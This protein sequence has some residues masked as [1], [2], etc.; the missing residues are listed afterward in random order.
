M[1]LDKLHSLLDDQYNWPDHYTFKFVG[2]DEHRDQLTEVIG[3]APTNER[4]SSSGKYISYSFQI[5]INAS[6]EVIEI[7]KKVSVISGIITL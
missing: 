2:K 3:L 7:Y 4:P 6:H 1:N 5:K